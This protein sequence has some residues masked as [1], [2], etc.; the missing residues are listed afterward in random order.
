MSELYEEDFYGW[1][2]EQAKLLKSGELNKLDIENIIEEVEDMGKST[3]RSLQSYI[4]VLLTH[5]LKWKYQPERRGSSWKGSILNSRDQIEDILKESPSLKNKIDGIL[6]TGYERGVRNAISETGLKKNVFPKENPWTLEEILNDDFWP[7]LK[8]KNIDNFH[9]TFLGETYDWHPP[10]PK[11]RGS[12]SF[13]GRLLRITIDSIEINVFL[14]IRSNLLKKGF[15]FEIAPTME[16]INELNQIFGSTR[17]VWN[18]TLAKTIKEYRAFKENPSI[19]KPNVSSTGLAYLAK[20]LRE[21]FE[22]LKEVSAISIQQKLMDLGRA[23]EG[24]FK[25]G[26]FPKFKSKSHNRDSFRLTTSG[27]KIKDNNLYIA[28]IKTPIKVYWSRDLPNNPS[29]VTISKNS[30]W[31]ILCFFCL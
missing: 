19:E 2:K 20:P 26:G 9:R 30:Y 15:K 3:K 23:Y 28:K 25:K 16:Q 6:K 10:L 17:F 11:G 8:I 7:N 31:S 12:A 13:S 1:T 22:F 24:F 21:E 27:F 29:S 18:Q 4:V 5:L 14:T